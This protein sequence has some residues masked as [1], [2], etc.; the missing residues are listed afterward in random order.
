MY[1]VRI[2]YAWRNEA[3]FAK[4]RV[5]Q[6]YFILS[7]SSIQLSIPTFY[8]HFHSSSSALSPYSVIQ[9]QYSINT[10]QY[11][12]HFA[13]LLFFR[14]LLLLLLLLLLLVVVGVLTYYSSS[15]S[16]SSYPTVPLWCF[17]LLQLPESTTASRRVWLPLSTTHL[18][19]LLY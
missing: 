16:S 3:G 15:S 17:I 10:V 13:E 19:L 4:R 9:Y 11:H 12:D 5:W 8:S 2:K 18:L 7:P 1:S 6:R 14:C